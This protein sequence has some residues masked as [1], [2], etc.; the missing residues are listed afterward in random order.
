MES[1]IELGHTLS[2]WFLPVVLAI[3]LHE[4]AHGW[5]AEKFGDDTARRLG[6]VTFNP[7]RHIDPVGTIL[8]PGFLLLV[9]KLSGATPFLFGW[10]KPV[11]V[12]FNRLRKPKRDMIWVALAGPGIN[13]LMAFGAALLMHPVG[14]LDGSPLSWWV[15]YNLQNAALVNVILAVFNMLPLPPLDGGRVMTGILPL[16]LA[17]P[18]ARIEPFGIPILLGFLF[19]VPLLGDELGLDLNLIPNILLPAVG[20]VHA[21]IFTLAGW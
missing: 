16:R 6:R 10:A 13:V 17:I 19:I 20:A 8:L 4:A 3:T 18:Y 1:L 12:A 9:T 5:V 11:P 14:Q 7:I 21:L 15:W 2:V